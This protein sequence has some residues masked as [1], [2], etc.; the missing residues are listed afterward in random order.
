MTATRRSDLRRQLPEIVHR[1]G[2]CANMIPCSK[3]VRPGWKIHWAVLSFLCGAM[4]L[5]PPAGHA[6]RKGSKP[7]QAQGDFVDHLG[8]FDTARWVKADGWKNGIPFDN[9]WS[10]DHV[11]FLD[12]TMLLSLDD[13]AALGEPYSSGHYQTIGFHGYGCFEASF[14]PVARSG[15]VSSFF[16][17]A[18]P[19]DNGGN[20]HVNEI[21]IEFLGYD[22]TMLQANFWTNDD[23]FSNGHEQLVPLGF[24]ASLDFHRYGFRWT[25]TGIE[26]FVDGE[27][28]YEVFDSPAEPTPKAGESLQKIMMNVW[29]VDGTASG[30]AGVFDYPG[31]ALTGIYDWVRYEAGEDCTFDA[32][33]GPP[34]PPPDGDPAELH[35]AGIA[36]D[37]NRQGSQV[38]ARVSVVD[39][40]GQPV[41]NADVGGAWSGVISNGDTARTT[42]GNGVAVFYSARSRNPGQ[43]MFCVTSVLLNGMTYDPAGN[44]ESCDSISK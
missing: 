14:M 8:T 43:V 19:F 9:A 25:S 37:L 33:P 13:E 29:P 6:A 42:D 21:D 41:A 10:A 27:S 31:T 23:D 39:G 17:F 11:S 24:D 28:V 22:T 40:R 2:G 12:G 1:Q 34:P 44:A 18:G 5:A 16:T 35:V 36:L 20:G 7:P 30:W 4:V 26:W 3:A 38:I 32:P 15:V